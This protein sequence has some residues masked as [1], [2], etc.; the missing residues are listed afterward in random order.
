MINKKL[1]VLKASD[2]VS[3]Q[4]GEWFDRGA[5][6]TYYDA[7]LNINNKTH[8]IAWKYGYNAGDKQSIDEALLSAGYRVRNNNKNIHKAYNSITVYKTS[9]LKRELNK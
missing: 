9:K 2:S 6:N 7:T 3:M 5:G 1:K 8:Y 4:F